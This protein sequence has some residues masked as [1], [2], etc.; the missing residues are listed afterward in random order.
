MVGVRGGLSYDIARGM[1][2]VLL[3]AQPMG[4]VFTSRA[5]L[6]LAEIREANGDNVSADAL[7]V[8]LPADSAGRWWTWAGTA[9][10]RT[11]QVSLPTVVDPRQ[12]IDEKSL[13]LLPGITDAEFSAAL[14]GVEWRE[15]AV[16]ANALRD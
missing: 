7:I 4:V 13:R 6:K 3:G 10:N 11:L 9:A 8:R 14:D 12:R 1:R 16:D 5:S 15:P 2:S